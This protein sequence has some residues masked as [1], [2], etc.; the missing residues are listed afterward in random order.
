MREIIV[1]NQNALLGI[2]YQTIITKAKYA[3]WAYTLVVI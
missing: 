2:N 3:T 1:M